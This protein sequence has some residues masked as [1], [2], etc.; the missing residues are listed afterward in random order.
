MLLRARCEQPAL[1]LRHQL[2]SRLADDLV[3]RNV[4]F[5]DDGFNPR[6]ALGKWYK[7]Q[8]HR[9]DTRSAVC[10]NFCWSVGSSLDLHRL[11]AGA[12]RLVGTHDFTS[13]C[14][15]RA[16]SN[17][18]TEC[19]LDSIQVQEQGEMIELDFKG[20]RFL[21]KMIRIMVGTLVDVAQGKHEPEHISYILQAK[22]RRHAG[23]AAPGRGLTLM[24]VLY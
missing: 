24:E 22:D 13:F 23:L 19:R 21:Y 15:P 14:D 8:L 16:E 2:N 10:R 7:Y 11:R 5:P 20:N 12:C 1:Q 17:G 3:I 18:G 4:D 6:C 9:G